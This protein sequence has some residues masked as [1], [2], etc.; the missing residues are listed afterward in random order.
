MSNIDWK[1]IA[2]QNNMTTEEFEG[3]ILLVAL[4]I[5]SMKLEDSDEGEAL[6]ITRGGHTLYIVKGEV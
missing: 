3:E 5:G 4:A 1:A 2:L 6:K